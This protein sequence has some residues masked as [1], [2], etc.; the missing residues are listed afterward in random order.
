MG[1]LRARHEIVVTNLGPAAGANVVLDE[2][3]QAGEQLVSTSIG[4]AWALRGAAV[5]HC[6]L[7][8][9]A[10]RASFTLAVDT[11]LPANPT[12]SFH[13]VDVG[14]DTPSVSAAH[15]FGS[16]PAVGDWRYWI[17]AACASTTLS[18]GYELPATFAVAPDETVHLTDG[19]VIRR[20][21]V[22][23]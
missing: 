18:D 23:V 8:T 17:C 15:L 20:D 6:S 3:L 10:G 2:Q 4:S 12:D 22:L 21:G 1:G 11:K 14:S 7:G 9:L 16:A 19:S 5:L 13:V